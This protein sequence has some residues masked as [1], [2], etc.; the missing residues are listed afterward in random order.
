MKDGKRLYGKKHERKAGGRIG[1]KRAKTQIRM[2][3]Y[4]S[5]S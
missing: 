2:G 5:A 1:R 4:D 3:N